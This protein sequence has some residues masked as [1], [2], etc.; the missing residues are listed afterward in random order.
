M[1]GNTKPTAAGRLPKL[2][3]PKSKAHRD[4]TKR[5]AELC[6]K[7][8]EQVTAA[9]FR[10]VKVVIADFAVDMAE[11]WEKYP[12][13]IGSEFFAAAYRLIAKRIMAL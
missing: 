10:S 5:Q 13:A 12:I 9:E 11:S 4:L 7:T 8:L 1:T 2:R 3:L 6:G